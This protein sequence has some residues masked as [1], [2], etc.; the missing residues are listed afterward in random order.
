MTN[1]LTEVL[2]VL[3]PRQERF[4]LEYSRTGNASSA[5][6]LAGYS[7]ASARSQGSYLLTNPN[8]LARVR[9][10]QAEWHAQQIAAIRDHVAP[11]IQTLAEI[12][13]GQAD[14]KGAQARVLASCALLDRAGFQPIQ[15]VETNQQTAIV[16]QISRDD[17]EL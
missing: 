7:P 6:T 3:P 1:E 12:A 4:A 13:A 14:A 8:I 11:A 15:K 2:D 5:A 16:V 17:M 10:L 9:E